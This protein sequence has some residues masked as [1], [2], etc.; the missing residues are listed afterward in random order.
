[1]SGKGN[2]FHPE[3]KGLVLT[4][5]MERLGIRIV[6][7]AVV[8]Q[9]CMDRNEVYGALDETATGQLEVKAKVAIDS[10]E[11]GDIAYWVGLIRPMSEIFRALM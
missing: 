10:T 6:Y 1:M 7:D 3:C 9:V 8:A 4:D 11:D 5:Y 2:G